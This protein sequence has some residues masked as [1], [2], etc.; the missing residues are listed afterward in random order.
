LK[1]K[2][3][4]YF[5]FVRG[6]Q[7]SHLTHKSFFY[8]VHELKHGNIRVGIVSLNS[9][10]RSSQHG[11]DARR[12]IIG[13]HVVME[14]A[15]KISEC[16]IRL[17]LCHHPFEMLA[18]WDSKPVRQ[19][20]AKHFH[21][22]LNGH[23]HDS[24]ACVTKQLIGNLFVSTAGCLKPNEPFSGYT[25][26]QIDLEKDTITCLFRKWYGERGQFDQETAKAPNGKMVF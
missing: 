21:G 1:K 8:D 7:N 11:N 3:G 13:E 2:L 10:W 6:Y 17:C 4:S 23:V 12:L 9:S 5:D 22:L 19:T 20:V 16:E 25:I 24:E 15:A 18:D 26:I 14:A